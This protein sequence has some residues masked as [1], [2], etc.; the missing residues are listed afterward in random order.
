MLLCTF[1]PL[2][3]LVAPLRWCTSRTGE[4]EQPASQSPSRNGPLQPLPPCLLTQH[5]SP[6]IPV[7]SMDGAV[8]VLVR[9][10]G[11]WRMEG[12]ECSSV[13]CRSGVG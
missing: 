3:F 13:V 8:R 7:R 5:L 10:Q 4:W 1:F 11:S 9:V 2:L 12:D 6:V